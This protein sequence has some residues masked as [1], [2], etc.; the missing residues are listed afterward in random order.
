M[1]IP[2]PVTVIFKWCFNP[3]QANRMRDMRDDNNVAQDSDNDR[4]DGSKQG[5]KQN[6]TSL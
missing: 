3:S 5:H 6:D 4:L 2:S 1:L